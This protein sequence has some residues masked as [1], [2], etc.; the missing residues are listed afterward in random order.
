MGGQP[1]D[2]SII[3]TADVHKQQDPLACKF[4]CLSEMCTRNADYGQGVTAN[5]RQG[6]A[7]IDASERQIRS[8]LALLGVVEKHSAAA[9]TQWAGHL[10][11][12]VRAVPDASG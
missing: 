10:E 11:R 3:V 9:N 12:L 1:A 6:G 2:R 4:Q 8:T 5:E 7:A